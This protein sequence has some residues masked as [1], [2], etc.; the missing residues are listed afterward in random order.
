[1]HTYCNDLRSKEIEISVN[2]LILLQIR[3]T[4]FGWRFEKL[5]KNL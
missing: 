4:Y 2:G 3:K 5:K 1:M